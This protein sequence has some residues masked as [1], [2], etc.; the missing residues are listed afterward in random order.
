MTLTTESVW[1]EF[2]DRLRG[3]LGRRVSSAA[4]VDDLLSDVFV[5]VHSRIE[6]LEDETRLAPW[7][8]QITRNTLTDYY[9][10]RPAP[11]A[12]LDGLDAPTVED[13]EDA[14]ALIAASMRGLVDRLPPKYREAL[15][16]T[17]F[18]GF[19]QAEMAAELGLSVSGAKSRVQRARAML[20][21]DLLEC[22]H[23]EFDRRG[24]VIDYEPRPRCCAPVPTP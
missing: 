1:R 19:T 4:D 18:E 16:L 13:D 22:C 7:L 11:A 21:D 20:R 10:R 24:N 3:F 15:V 9:R 17:E 23:F 2:S 14:A 5:K 6:T 12:A 8:F